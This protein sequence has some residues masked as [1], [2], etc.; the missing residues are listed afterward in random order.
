MSAHKKNR[1]HHRKQD[2]GHP[3]LDKEAAYSPDERS[4]PKLEI[5]L[6]CDTS[7]S[8][9]A[10]SNGLVPLSQNRIRISVIHAGVGP[11]SKS[12]IFLAETGS[13]L[14]VGFN[15]G[16]TPHIEQVAAEHNVEVRI[17]DVI[18]NLL[19]DLKNIAQS[20]IPRESGEYISGSAKV[21][22]LFKSSRKGII[23]GCEIL[24]GR[25]ALGDTFRVV[26]AMGPVYKGKINSLHIE[27]NAVRQAE[28]GQQ[29]GLK[30]DDFKKVSVG[31]LV[32]AFQPAAQR[33]PQPWQPRGKIFYF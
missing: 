12:D 28:K 17:H 5:V 11:V 2:A 10:I 18:Y 27:K 24:R 6:K 31:D 25:L 7:G 3:A 14:V 9:E 1:Q 26:S 13:R 29:V 32:E 16:K 20:L 15:V 23:L 4:A 30:L 8:I 22:A 33:I 21:I 19:E